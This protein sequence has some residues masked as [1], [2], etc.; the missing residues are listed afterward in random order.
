MGKSIFS[1][2]AVVFFAFIAGL[3]LLHKGLPPTH[4]GEYHIIRFYQFD[5]TLR[6]GQ[7]YPRWQPDVNK[8]YGSPLLNYYYPLPN[9]TASL[10]H[11]F[12]SSFID[13]FKLQMFFAIIFGAVFSY[14]WIKYFFG[15]I[16]GV[17]GSVIYTFAPYHFVDIYV[18]GSVGE[19]WALALFPAFLWS[20][21]KI[22]KEKNNNAISLSCIFL[23]LI[24]FSHN[25][26][27]LLFF[28]FALVYSFVIC[29]QYKVN[30][31]ILLSV[32]ATFLLGLSISSIFWFP[33]LMEREYVK[34]LEI[35]DVTRHFVEP[36]QLL[37]PSWGTGFSGGELQNQM[38]FQIGIINTCI[39]FLSLLFIVKLF[40][41]KKNNLFLIFFM[42]CF[43]V[44]CF[45]MLEQST[46]LWRYL[47]L[48]EYTQFPWRLLSLIILICAFLGGLVVG[49]TS[50]RLKKIISIIFIILAILL[51]ISYTKP[52]Y[53]HDRND[54]YYFEKPNFIDGTNTPGNAF[55]TIWLN[56]SL[57]RESN[58]INVS[59]KE[60]NI[61]SEKYTSVKYI[62]E[63]TALKNSTIIVN[64]A[65]FPGWVARVDGQNRVIEKTK[66]GII[67]LSL[68]EGR[69]TVEFFYGS[70]LPRT[71]GVLFFIA[72]ILLVLPLRKILLK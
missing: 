35:Y 55:N 41:T 71:I 5:K 16:A 26:L 22:V 57:P 51:T 34:G 33:A 4:D 64:T 6:D 36:Y 19:V 46:F 39:I 45:L 9:Y 59:K 32:A 68:V 67:A 52:A 31:K 65:Y 8:G 21:T 72:S 12:G 18:R 20:L 60:G 54:T 42:L 66:D 47:P 27:A 58:K 29:W 13:A 70:T 17:V 44:I 30:K 37:F 3:P 23:A 69:H 40:I 48:I 53:Y 24:I 10:F 1:I 38:T 28:P 11:Y 56:P 63:M 15:E 7:W 49:M 14:L 62:I 2:V 61:I 43:F 25:I 50:G